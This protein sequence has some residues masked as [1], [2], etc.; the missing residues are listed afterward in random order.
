V[1]DVDRRLSPPVGRGDADRSEDPTGVD[2]E[3]VRRSAP[4]GEPTGTSVV[5]LVHVRAL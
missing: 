4:A 5:R 1:S 3:R 2:T